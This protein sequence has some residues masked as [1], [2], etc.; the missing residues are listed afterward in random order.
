MNS[1]ALLLTLSTAILLVSIIG[2]IV[3]NHHIRNGD[4]K[5][6]PV[7]RD[8]E[9]WYEIPAR[10]RIPVFVAYGAIVGALAG[11]IL[12]LVAP[13]KL[14]SP[15][16][17]QWATIVLPFALFLI[18]SNRTGQHPIARRRITKVV[19]I[20]LGATTALAVIHTVAS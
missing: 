17:L 5:R 6:E 19:S 4:F 8:D 11:A 16:L 7:Q 2:M 9:E 15:Q 1:Q 3:L 18:D 20:A 12:A 14:L 10:L 13:R